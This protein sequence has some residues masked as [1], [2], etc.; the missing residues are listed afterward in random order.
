MMRIIILALIILTAGYTYGQK[1]V[2]ELKPV[3]RNDDTG[4]PVNGATIE[5]YKNGSLVA[6]ESSGSNGK[7]PVIELP[8]CIGCTYKVF[9]KKS[10]FVTKTAIMDG[11]A[12][13][14][15]ELPPGVVEQRFEVTI[16]ESV[17]DI[18]FS[19]L[20]REPMVEMAIQPDG[21]ITFDQ[22]KIKVMKK[23]IEALRNKNPPD[24]EELEKEAKENEKKEADFM[25]YV[26]AG[27]AFV[28]KTE[29][30]KA[31]GQYELA[32]GLKPTHQPTK[33]K[34]Q[35]AKIRLEELRANEALEKEF[36]EKM[37][38]GKTA[39]S[40]DELE[41]ALGL[42]R[43]ASSLK[44]SEQLPIKY[45]A[46]IEKELADQKN[47]EAAF[48][49]LVAEGDNAV[50]SENFDEGISKYQAALVL[51]QDADVKAKL[52]AAK[53]KKADKEAALAEDKA[54]QDKY[55]QLIASAD[56]AF[57]KESYDEAKKN[58][59]E[60]LK[61]KPGEARPTS[62]LA[63]IADILKKK[64]DEKAA[65]EK[66]E[67][68]YN[69]LMEEGKG[70]INQRSWDDAKSKH[71]EAL[72][73]KPGDSEALAQ[74]DLIAKEKEKEAG[75]AKMNAEYN[76]HMK[77]A[78]SLF[79]QKKHNEAK[80][81]YSAAS[82]VK[83]KEQAPID[84]IAKIEALLA[85]QADAAQKE[86]QY[87]NMMAEGDAA[88][89][90][91]DY[92]EAIDRYN[93]A[94]VAKPGDATA[95]SKID[96]ANKA[97][98]DAKKLAE[99]QAKFDG[100]V[101]DGSRSFNASDY[102][103]AKLNYN[104]ALGIKEDADVRAKIK[105]IDEL[106]AKNQSEAETKAKYDSAIKEAEE[107]EKAD[108][109]AKAMDK[110]KAAVSI[111]D[112]PYPKGKIL[113]LEEKLRLNEE[114]N[115]LNKQF[116]D[117]VAE[118]DAAYTA[119]DYAKALDKYKEA[120]KVK[121]DP[122]ISDKIKEVA[123]K[124]EEENQ[125]ADKQAQYDKKI[126]EAD[127]AF[128]DENWDGARALYD[129]ASAIKPTETYPDA[130]IAEI[131]KR[132]KAE[133]L[134][135]T[136]RQYQKIIDKAD[137]LFAS[138]DLNDSKG[139]Y[140]RA[141]GF[142]PT[143]TYAKA[144]IDKIEQINVDREKALADE[145]ELNAKYDALIK[146]GESAM[147]GA[148]WQEALDK[149]N[150][151]LVLKPGES[152]PLNKIAEIKSK[153]DDADLAKKKEAEYLAMLSRADQEFNNADYQNSI[154]TYNEALK[155]KP[156]EKYPL[157]KIA[158][159]ESMLKQAA[160]D[161]D[162]EAYQK[163]LAEAQDKYDAKE[164]D[165]ALMLYQQ[166][167]STK[168]TDPLPRA[169]IDEIKQ[170]QLK[171]GNADK[172]EKDYEAL[173]L[174]ADNQFEKG[175]WSVA[176]ETYVKAYN[177]FNRPWP[178]DRIKLC[179]E[180]M[181]AQTDAT[182]NKSY[183]KIIK[184]AD[185]YFNSAEYDKAKEY[186]LRAVGLKSKDQYPKDQLKEIEQI[187]NPQVAIKTKTHLTN[188]GQ[189]N[190]STN[191]VDV[192][193]MLANAEV[194][195]KNLTTIR[196]EQQGLDAEAANNENKAAQEEEN[197]TTREKVV[198]INKDIDESVIAPTLQRRAATDSVEV[199][200][201][202]QAVVDRDRNEMND[203]DIQLQNQRVNNIVSEIEEI[204]NESDLPRVGYLLDVDKIRAEIILENELEDLAQTNVTYDQK[205]YVEQ[206]KENRIEIDPK[207]DIPRINTE[208]HVEDHNIDLINKSNISSWDQEDVVMETKDETEFII[209]EIRANE[210]EADIPR[211]EHEL[212]VEEGF[213]ARVEINSD[214]RDDQYDVTVDQKIYTENIK[215]EIEIENLNND[216]PREQME[217]FVE[218]QWIENSEKSDELMVDQ[219]NILF[220]SD[221]E[222][223]KLE[224]ERVENAVE[225]DKNREG[226]EVVLDSMKLDEENYLDNKAAE[227]LD[228]SH[229]TFDYLEGNKNDQDEA[230]KNSDETADKNIDDTSEMV[231]GMKEEE[232]ELA[233]DSEEDRI[234]SE[235]YV[236][237]L[238]D[239]DITKIDQQTKNDLGDQF[240]EGMTEEV[241]T[242]N[243]EDGL[244]V[245]FVVRRIVVING[246]GN[247][248]E[249]VQTK[250]GTISYSCNGHGISEYEWDDKSDAGDL[251]RH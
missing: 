171:A 57:D 92:L 22:Q 18:D 209:D 133:S 24:K 101:A 71:E 114:A 86:E 166:A 65:N 167:L 154:V 213:V 14:P 82:S 16:F 146:D 95:Q 186:Y 197:Y 198:T 58:Y 138:D 110:Y 190:R 113:E 156:G 139:L 121:P 108:D 230:L 225:D 46:E 77:E 9:V 127:A 100:F 79:D 25:A 123:L 42:Y 27:D 159:A 109:L 233:V 66:L 56:G 29:Y 143:D 104:N 215:N 237:S 150:A 116:E 67:A 182:V 144:Q 169:R 221:V 177:L 34:I 54:N 19:F 35:D 134:E 135:E 75:E 6:K 152:Y 131:E 120:L 60:A 38:A 202:K 68:D 5:V 176:K 235:E 222:L 85:D 161:K 80:N 136:E 41:K 119:N 40:A 155:M 180:N 3:V 232:N 184:K 238:R 50:G 99:D 140:E 189:P 151:S 250:F 211:E 17:P 83:P 217:D 191:S 107:A 118:G 102:V 33:D 43:E 145:K 11:H 132:M 158:S 30:E 122:K 210:L 179:T 208:I 59:E 170:I 227:N 226:Y 39:R 223:E 90:R 201:D 103:D 207:R 69:R 174:E 49:K 206:Y 48:N 204:D 224:I 51:K 62:Q 188:Y 234:V 97:I 137:V 141:L 74:I 88:N 94:L 129:D 162:E 181:Q 52:D 214:R 61:L 96:E 117:L 7:V 70:K 98:A 203:N 247:V 244:M 106:I 212:I 251:V 32:L 236:E 44:P 55:N 1:T 142:K 220:D 28:K 64:A 165:A 249:K 130:Q 187:L 231:E 15:K 126:G 26:E 2:I 178:E 91:K 73:L 4:K 195:R 12:N 115:A 157:D 53:K 219:N 105:E 241:Y 193:K 239:I 216:L 78:K 199:M 10:G 36:A 168:P 163:L 31:I 147:T 111:K 243:D 84:E 173:I 192:A 240:P 205:A 89:G 196:T 183:N 149:F 228:E 13:Y 148:Q 20:E 160:S 63:A 185:G 218:V 37:T 124:L 246:E 93:K 23:K 248:Y 153:M 128:D 72:R 245:S 8:V 242:I 194:E 164:Y 112:D 172:L 175:D 81:K 87:K 125:N 200:A 76:A 47:N 21:F 229:K 45:I